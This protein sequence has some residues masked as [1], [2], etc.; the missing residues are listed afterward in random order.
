VPTTPDCLARVQL[1]VRDGAVPALRTALAWATGHS[2]EPFCI[3][4]SSCGSRLC[5]T[6]GVATAACVLRGPER[7]PCCCLSRAAPKCARASRT[8]SSG[9]AH[10]LCTVLLAM[11]SRAQ[12]PSPSWLCV[13][14]RGRTGGKACRACR[15]RDVPSTPEGSRPLRAV[16]PRLRFL[17]TSRRDAQLPSSAFAPTP[18]DGAGSAARASSARAWACSAAVAVTRARSSS[19]RSAVTGG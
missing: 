12:S 5:N 15:V 7:S 3:S 17:M 4:V 9:S 14:L 18:L 16:L 2:L 6:C 11:T 19:R 1:V 8:W 13:P 10:C